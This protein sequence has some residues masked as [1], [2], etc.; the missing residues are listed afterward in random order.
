[1]EWL[2]DNWFWV[3]IAA[4]FI[5]MHFFGHGHGGHGGHKSEDSKEKG[6]KRPSGHR[7]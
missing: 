2:T 5:G 3:L 1:M 4:L 7:H 6:S